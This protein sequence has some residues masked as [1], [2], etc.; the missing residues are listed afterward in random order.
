MFGFLKS[1]THCR[2]NK[3]RKGTAKRRLLRFEG[4]EQRKM[5]TNGDTINL[6]ISDANAITNTSM[7]NVSFASLSY[8]NTSAGAL[9]GVFSDTQ[10]GSDWSPSVGKFS[11]DWKNASSKPFSGASISFDPNGVSNGNITTYY[12]YVNGTPTTAGLIDKNSYQGIKIVRT[13]DAQHGN[14]QTEYD[15]TP[16]FWVY[17]SATSGMTVTTVANINN[18][19][20]PLGITFNSSEFVAGATSITNF[21]GTKAII[22]SATCQILASSSI[23]VGAT[24]QWSGNLDVPSGVTLTNN[25]TN[26]AGYANYLPGVDTTPVFDLQGTCINQGHDDS[27][28]VINPSIPPGIHVGATGRWKTVSG[29]DGRS[30]AVWVYAWDPGT[31]ENAGTYEFQNGA[32]VDVQG[33]STNATF[34]NDSG[35]TITF[36]YGSTMTV[37]GTLTNNGELDNYGSI[38]GTGSLDNNLYM[39]IEQ[40][41]TVTGTVT[42]GASGELIFDQTSA[43]TCAVNVSGSGE[44]VDQAYAHLTLTGT[45]SGSL[46]VEQDASVSDVL[47]LTGSNSFSGYTDIQG[48][49]ILQMGSNNCLN[50]PYGAPCTLDL[51]GGFLDLNGWN[52]T[53]GAIVNSGTGSGYIEN[54]ANGT[55]S[56]FGVYVSSGTETLGAIIGNYGGGGGTISFGKTGSGTLV[57]T[58]AETYAGGTSVNAGTLQFGSGGS[59][60]GYAYSTSSY[61]VASGATMAFDDATGYHDATKPLTGSGYINDISGGPGDTVVLGNAS[62]WSGTE[63]AFVTV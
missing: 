59:T 25:G 13:L 43:S 20:I 8:P 36:D 42:N 44:L 49:S 26:Q 48:S 57:L 41:A 14:E 10:S 33:G 22:S 50:G 37:E 30:K 40:G 23:G 9:V 2:Q 47:T 52:L 27:S 63:S 35:G 28:S 34:T 16:N 53:V 6:A 54:M 12:I 62:G 61:Y 19:F 32:S 7:P 24:F 18:V 56:D 21:T 4:L 31:F 3:P 46:T 60:T 17:A 38:S 39:D 11:V 51:N 5:M 29:A 55:T 58:A 45:I 1:R 15:F